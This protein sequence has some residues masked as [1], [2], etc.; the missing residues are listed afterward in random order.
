MSEYADRD[1]FE[2]IPYYGKHVLAMTAEGLHNKSDI[3]AELAHRDIEID[4]LRAELER[5]EQEHDRATTLHA[6]AV[7]ERD[8]LAAL[9]REA[10]S[11]ATHVRVMND[12][13]CRRID[14]ALAASEGK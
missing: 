5:E 6:T 9:L 14:A 7:K 2:L 13:L 12:D 1:V 4:R 10:R 11:S 3:A 8:A